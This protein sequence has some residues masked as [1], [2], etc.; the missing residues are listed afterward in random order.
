M[1]LFRM[2][3]NSVFSFFLRMFISSEDGYE[4]LHASV[5]LAHTA[6]LSALHTGLSKITCF[7]NCNVR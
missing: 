7:I 2:M 1:F 6:I 4:R 3:L 5:S